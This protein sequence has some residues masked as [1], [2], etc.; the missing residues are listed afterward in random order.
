MPYLG[1]VMPPLL[2]S[3]QLKPDV[4]ITDA[5]SEAE[6][7][8]DDEVET[9]YLGDRKI[10]IRTSSLEEKATA[11]NMICCYLDELKGGFCPYVK[12]VWQLCIIA[13]YMISARDI[14]A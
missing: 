8:E 12:E 1:T 5:D 13:L 11:C 14:C 3:A 9:I 6:D 7:E 4:N 2:A 10:S